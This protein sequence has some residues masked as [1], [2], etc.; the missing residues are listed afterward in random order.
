MVWDRPRLGQFLK[1]PLILGGFV[2]LYSEGKQFL[3]LEFRFWPFVQKI[4]FGLLGNQEPPPPPPPSTERANKF[5]WLCLNFFGKRR[6]EKFDFLLA[7]LGSE[8][9]GAGAGSWSAWRT[10]SSKFEILLWLKSFSFLS[11][12][13]VWLFV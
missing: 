11:K 8:R 1:K 13:F 3:L 2:N 6:A 5:Y 9:F 4:I 10:T 7:K 12:V